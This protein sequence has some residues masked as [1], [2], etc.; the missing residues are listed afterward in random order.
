MFKQYVKNHEMVMMIEHKNIFKS[1]TS[2]DQLTIPFLTGIYQ[3]QN[4][5]MDLLKYISHFNKFMFQLIRDKETIIS[6]IRETNR[7]FKG[8]MDS[9]CALSTLRD[10]S[11][12]ALSLNLISEKKLLV[13]N[14]IHQYNF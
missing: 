10:L 6:I 3:R 4:K 2:S 1:I 8:D 9:I 13:K 12:F 7:T 11:S 14:I 5:G